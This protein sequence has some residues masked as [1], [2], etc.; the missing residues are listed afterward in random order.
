MPLSYALQ[1]FQSERGGDPTLASAFAVMTIV[2]ALIVFFL[3]QK[4]IM[5]NAAV[6]GFGGR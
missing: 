1:L 6:S 2:P 3:A 5:E 4:Q